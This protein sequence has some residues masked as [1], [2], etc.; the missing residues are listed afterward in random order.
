MGIRYWEERYQKQG[1]LTV[2]CCSF[3]AKEFKKRTAEAH[4][5]LTQCLTKLNIRADAILDLG[6]GPGRM[7]D[8]YRQFCKRIIGIDVVPWAI[9]EAK[10][11]YVLGEFYIYNGEKIPLPD[12]CVNLVL[13]WTVLQHIAPDTIE[14]VC[15]EIV[16]VMAPHSFLITYENVSVWHANKEHI[17]FRTPFEYR[18]MLSGLTFVS[19]QNIEKADGNNSDERHC[20]MVFKKLV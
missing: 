5:L 11:R 10:K 20:L 18:G 6:C 16:R 7:V 14:Q 8:S 12:G 9:D 2:G 3:N 15:K 4:L 17:W 1:E 13:T 19:E